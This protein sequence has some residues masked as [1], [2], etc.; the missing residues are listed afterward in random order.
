V[1]DGQQG[2]E[3]DALP[4]GG[5]TVT[6]PSRRSKE[7]PPR[8]PKCEHHQGLRSVTQAGHRRDASVLVCLLAHGQVTARFPSGWGMRPFPQ[9]SIARPSALREFRDS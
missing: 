6:G 9:K 7:A 3:R 8:Q 1:L 4:Q 2:E 5:P